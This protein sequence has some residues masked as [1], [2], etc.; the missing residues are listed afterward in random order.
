MKYSEIE[1]EESPWMQ[2]AKM[3]S[4]KKSKTQ[5]SPNGCVI[6]DVSEEE[7]LLL[8]IGSNG[9]SVHDKKCV[10]KDNK[11]EHGIGYDL[12]G[13]CTPFN[14]GEISAIRNALETHS[15]E[16]LK[17]LKL[18]V[19]L[20]GHYYCCERCCDMLGLIGVKEVTLIEGAEKLFKK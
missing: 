7:E 1:L 3:L 14:H 18:K 8:G 6:V 11:L 5:R 2:M 17:E 13:A 10:R 15:I 16:E 4:A 19:F 9:S 12:C 20:Y